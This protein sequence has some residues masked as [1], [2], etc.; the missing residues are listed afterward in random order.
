MRIYFEYGIKHRATLSLAS[1]G[2]VRLSVP[3]KATWGVGQHYNV[4][5]V[6]LGLHGWTVHPF[7]ACSLP[8]RVREGQ[9]VDSELILHVRPRG[10]F[11]ARLAKHAGHHPNA[12]MRILLYGP[13]GGVDMRRIVSSDRF[14]VVAG[15]SGAGWMIPLISAFQRRLALEPQGLPSMRVIL[16]TRDVATQ[17]WFE[18]AITDLSLGDGRLMDHL[19]LEMFYTGGCEDRSAPRYTGQFLAKPDDLE[20]APVAEQ[21]YEIHSNYESSDTKSRVDGVRHFDY[22]PDLPGMVEREAHEGDRISVLVCGPLSMQSDVANAV[23]RQQASVLKG[24]SR[25]IYLHL[26]HFSWA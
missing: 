23:A 1:N 16:A 20:K 13:Y 11:T 9:S 4:R 19:K 25:D 3:T 17:R 8:E 18:D 22:R 7:T 26:E 5:L 15:G 2:F 14:L 6:G 24:A 10:G 12:K 21:P